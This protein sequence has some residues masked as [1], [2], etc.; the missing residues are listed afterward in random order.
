MAAESGMGI[1]SL[2]GL[3]PSIDLLER[4]PA[5][6]ADD[7]DAGA[8]VS[9][10]VAQPGDIRHLLCTISRRR[11]RPDVGALHFYVTEQ[12]VEVLARHLLL[13]QIVSDWELPIRQRANLFLEAFGNSLLQERTENYVGAMGCELVELACNGQGALEELVDL[14]LLKYR[15]RDALVDVFHSWAPTSPFDVEDLRDH[16]LRAHYGQRYDHRTNLC[17]WDYQMRI[18][19]TGATVIHPKLYK[20]WR[21]TG[22]AF[23]FGEQIYDHPNRTHGS[24]VEGMMKKGKDKGMKK[25]IRGYWIDIVNSPYVSLGVDCETSHDEFA[26]GLFEVQNKGTGT[27]QNRHHCVEVAVYNMLAYLWEI[28]TGTTYSMSKAHDIYSGLGEDASDLMNTQAAESDDSSSSSSSSAAAAAA[29]Q[30]GN[31]SLRPTTEDDRRQQALVRARCIVQTFENVKVFPIKGGVDTLLGKKQFQGLF[32][33]V[34]LSAGAAHH[35]GSEDFGSILKPNAAVMVEAAKFAVV[36]S[37]EQEADY[38]SRI[39]EMAEARGLRRVG[40]AGEG[41]SRPAVFAFDWTSAGGK[42]RRATT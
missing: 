39:F 16:R 42:A 21:N 38:D 4:V 26:A 6:V 8:T 22:I 13:L 24:Y 41:S 32:D 25:E 9:L 12:P 19:P 20:T 7:L 30:N 23:E 29:D 15:D 33:V 40:P 10:L 35:L 5:A 28:E 11:R 3:S 27:E 17:D 14:S 36:L 2:W 18:K 31:E 37:K 1:H 34:S